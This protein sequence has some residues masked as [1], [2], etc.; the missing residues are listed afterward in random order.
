MGIGTPDLRPSRRVE[1]RFV[2]GDLTGI[3]RGD[4]AHPNVYDHTHYS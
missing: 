2:S 1:I 3:R 4:Y